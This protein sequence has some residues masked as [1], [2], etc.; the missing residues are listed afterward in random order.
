MCERTC[1]IISIIIIIII[2]TSSIRYTGS[3]DNPFIFL[4][5]F[6]YTLHIII[7][8]DVCLGGYIS[9][10]NAMAAMMDMHTSSTDQVGHS[11]LDWNGHLDQTGH[12][13]DR[14]RTAL[15]RL[16]VYIR[17]CITN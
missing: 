12:S 1:P 8:L 17:S 4:L 2:I 11:D 10:L 15:H 3:S 13:E 7:V 16:Q 14:K 6:H 5:F 9:G